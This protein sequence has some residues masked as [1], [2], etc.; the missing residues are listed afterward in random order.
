MFTSLKGSADGSGQVLPDRILILALQGLLE[1]LE[2]GTIHKGEPVPEKIYGIMASQAA[3][4]LLGG[5][6][7]V[8][9]AGV[10]SDISAER[11]GKVLLESDVLQSSHPQG[12]PAILNRIKVILETKV[13]VKPGPDAGKVVGIDR[14]VRARIV[15]FID[16]ILPM[17]AKQG[18]P[19][20]LLGEEGW[21]VLKSV[22]FLLR[23]PLNVSR[24]ASPGRA[25]DV[26][27]SL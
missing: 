17:V 7:T 12:V 9:I 24:P 4:L 3:A 16:V 18:N 23:L 10:A 15:K 22:A 6:K 19:M 21:E 20:N 1:I 11:I 27:K 8:E 2:K 13:L 25:E 26:D 14:H 5:N